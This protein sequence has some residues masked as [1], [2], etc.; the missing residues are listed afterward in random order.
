MA[1]MRGTLSCTA[2]II[3]LRGSLVMATCCK[4][5]CSMLT[6][7]MEKKIFPATLTAM[8]MVLLLIAVVAPCTTFPTV[9]LSLPLLVAQLT[10]CT[11]SSFAMLLPILGGI[12][13]VNL[14]ILPLFALLGELAYVI[15]SEKGLFILLLLTSVIFFFLNTTMVIPTI[16]RTLHM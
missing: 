12:P 7:Q 16:M 14:F 4:T 1:T 5:L 8:I 13:T 10:S 6:V 11:A 3:P 9:S 15:Y 2:S